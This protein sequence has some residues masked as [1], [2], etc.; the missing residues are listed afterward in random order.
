MNIGAEPTPIQ[1]MIP[2]PKLALAESE[3]IIGDHLFLYE[4]EDNLVYQLNDGAAVVWLLCDGEKNV[5]SIAREIG[6]TYA[7]PPQSALV[8][9]GEAVAQFQSLGLLQS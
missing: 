4:G 3:E 6:E 2:L 8:A 9:V 1:K 7:L 5:E